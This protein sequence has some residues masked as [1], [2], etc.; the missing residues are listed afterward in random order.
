MSHRGNNTLSQA[1]ARVR[2]VA[3]AARVVSPLVCG[4]REPHSSGAETQKAVIVK[5]VRATRYSLSPST[6]CPRV[7]AIDRLHSWVTPHT[8][9]FVSD[10]SSYVPPQ[11]I[12]QFF[13]TMLSALAPKTREA[14]AAGLLHFHQFCDTISLPGESR[15][16]ASEIIL[17]IFCSSWA[18][19][20]ARST[21]D[22]WLAGLRFW[23]VFLLKEGNA[24]RQ[25]ET[26][27]I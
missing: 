27:M 22:E 10:L 16:P 13:F 6:L 12:S 8:I 3:D 11:F 19:R 24:Q 5:R 18:G 23:H 17:A 7:L 14:Y 25:T 20:V 9:S 21:I 2:A 26:K 1:L 15:V 4:A